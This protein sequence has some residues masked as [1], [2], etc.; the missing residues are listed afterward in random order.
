MSLPPYER[1]AFGRRQTHEH[2]AVR[3]P[4]RPALRCT[5]KNISAGGA[6]LDF[7][8][9]VFLPYSFQLYWETQRRTEVCEIKHTKGSFVGVQFVTHA[10]ENDT[11]KMIRAIDLEGWVPHTQVLKR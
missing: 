1:R 4:G 6:L 8:E 11:D 9:K 7:G 5:I 10:A 3:I 2:A